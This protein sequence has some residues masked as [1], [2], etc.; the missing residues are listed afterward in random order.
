M[1]TLVVQLPPGLAVRLARAAD[2]LGMEHANVAALAL[3]LFLR[4]NT[5][6]TSRVKQTRKRRADR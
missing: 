5:P 6:G 4:A 1:T 2:E 3:R